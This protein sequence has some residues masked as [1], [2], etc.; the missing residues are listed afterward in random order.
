MDVP[1]GCKRGYYMLISV[2]WQFLCMLYHIRCKHDIY[3]HALPNLILEFN[4]N[5][6]SLITGSSATNRTTKC[7]AIGETDDRNKSVLS[8]FSRYLVAL[9]KHYY[10]VYQTVIL[11]KI[12]INYNTR[13]TSIIP[14]ITS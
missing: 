11:Q 12:R 8:V 7:F 5:K 6:L 10:P 3:D 4:V 1:V 14:F 13:R 9:R 2:L